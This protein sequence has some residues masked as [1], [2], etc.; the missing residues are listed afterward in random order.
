MTG[1]SL[2]NRGSRLSLRAMLFIAAAILAVGCAAILFSSL[3][4]L[5]NAA[6]FLERA[7]RSY[8]QLALVSQLEADVQTLLLESGTPFVSRAAA[9]AGMQSAKS[10]RAN[11][12]ERVLAVY[13]AS[14]RSEVDLLSEN[15][16]V[17]TRAD[18]L[19]EA[20]SL[21]DLFRAILDDLAR[22]QIADQGLPTQP[23]QFTPESLRLGERIAELRTRIHH[24]VE[25]ER[26]EVTATIAAMA[27]MRQKFAHWA[28]L[29]GLTTA[30]GLVSIVLYLNN[31]LIAPIAALRS[32]AEQIGRGQ[33]DVHVVPRG[34]RDLV[35]LGNQFND[36]TARLADQQQRLLASNETLEQTVGAR[37]KELEAKSA[38]LSE[39]DRSRR[40]FFAKIGHELRTPVTVL[41]GEAEVALRN[42]RADVSSLRET[43][44]HIV[45][46]GD[47]LQRRLEDFLAL[48]RSEDGRISLRKKAMDI[49]ACVKFATEQATAYAASSDVTLVCKGVDSAI[50]CEG[51]ESWLRQALLALIDNAVKFSPSDA[52]VS[53]GL[54]RAADTVGIEISDE[55]P[56]ASADVIDKLFD[57]YFQGESGRSRGGSGLGLA[58]AR[59]VAEQHHGSVTACNRRDRGFAVTIALPVTNEADS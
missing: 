26:D 25:G 16:E 30:I 2:S 35:E 7:H 40:L 12:I 3:S 53:V 33:I 49:A 18:E 54:V 20:T 11:E 50:I 13:M 10:D 42:S 46:S 22:L 41:R 32:S 34:A 44:R 58:V 39:I 19:Q 15:G 27:A 59:W 51:D 17:D 31:S 4:G 57:P 8:E 24:V 14:I 28:A 21:R 6:F 52:T 23:T 29:I 37:T 48:A 5:S 45:A 1:V 9:G 47:V 43:L 36:M 56:G 38:Q 55:G